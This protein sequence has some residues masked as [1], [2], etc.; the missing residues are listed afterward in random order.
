MK[1]NNPKKLSIALLSPLCFLMQP[2]NVL[3]LEPFSSLP[4]SSPYRLTFCLLDVLF[5]TSL[6]YYFFLLPLLVS[7]T[8]MNLFILSA[9]SIFLFILRHTLFILLIHLLTHH[10]KSSTHTALCTRILYV[11]VKPLPPPNLILYLSRTL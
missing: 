2:M 11:T 3:L 4:L 10:L 9:P 5:A 7:S 8:I 6:N 1:Q